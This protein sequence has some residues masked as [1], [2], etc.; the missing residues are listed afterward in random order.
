MIPG[1]ARGGSPSAWNVG[2]DAVYEKSA[3]FEAV[4]KFGAFFD[5]CRGS[6]RE[7]KGHLHLASSLG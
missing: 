1:L 2:G 4:P 6:T 5:C 3:I 7:T